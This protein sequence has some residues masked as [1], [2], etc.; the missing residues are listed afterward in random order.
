MSGSVEWI[1]TSP[2]RSISISTG[3]FVWRKLRR[4]ALPKSVAAM[5]GLI[6][7]ASK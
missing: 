7:E 1:S 6:L 3:H 2:F 4:R 5:V